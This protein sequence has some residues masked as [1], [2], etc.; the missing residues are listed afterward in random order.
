MSRYCQKNSSVLL[1]DANTETS[2]GHELEIAHNVPMKRCVNSKNQKRSQN[3]QPAKV[4]KTYQ[5]SEKSN[6]IHI[7]NNDGSNK[8]LAK[9]CLLL[10]YILVPVKF[11]SIFYHPPP[12]TMIYIFITILIFLFKF[13]ISNFAAIQ[14]TV[15]IVRLKEE[16]LI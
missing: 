5:S 12:N 15:R 16:D 9:V 10:C 11:Y 13:F 7:A 4:S 8:T 6:K 1:S 2:H 3:T 14:D